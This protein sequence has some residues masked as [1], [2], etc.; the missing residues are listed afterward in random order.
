M[1]MS[2]A[3][4]WVYLAMMWN[5]EYQAKR[6]CVQRGGNTLP[7]LC[8]S[9]V[10]LKRC[11]HITTKIATA[12]LTAIAKEPPQGGQY[13]FVWPRTVEGARQRVQFC[14]RMARATARATTTT[15]AKATKRG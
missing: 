1:A 5:E 13:G 3:E 11:G 12:M 14:R 10:Y 7:G 4:A 6:A 8:D 2:E 15:E 9:V